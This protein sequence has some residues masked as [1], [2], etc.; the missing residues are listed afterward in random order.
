M[1]EEISK[2]DLIDALEDAIESH[3]FAVFL[4]AGMS[5]DAG[6]SNWKNLLEKPAKKIKLDIEKESYDLLNLAQ[7]YCNRFSRTKI[8]DLIKLEYDKLNKPTKN[9]DLLAQLPIYTYWTTNYDT[10]IED[11]LRNRNKKPNIKLKDV[12]LRGTNKTYD[13][14]VYKMHDDKQ[15]P[16]TAVITRSDYENFG[17]D[18]RKFFRGILEG[19]LL[20]KT[21]LFLG[22][23]FT[24]PN[25][26]HVI[27]RLRVLLNPHDTRKH[28]CIMKRNKENE[29]SKIKQELQIED[30]GRYNIS[31]YL[32]DDFAEI[33]E[34]LQILV[35]KYRR[36][37][38]FISGAAMNYSPLPE[39][40]GEM[41]IQKLGY[42]L[43]KNNY[44][45]VNGYGE[46]VGSYL[47][48]GVALYC[49]ENNKKTSEFLILMPFPRCISNKKIDE[50]YSKHR[51]QMIE[52]CGIS[53]FLFGNNNHQEISNGVMEE[54]E[55][56]EKLGLFP[57]P[58][59]CTGSAAEYIYSKVLKS[60]LSDSE[61]SVIKSCDFDYSDID[62]TISR[63]LN[64]INKLNRRE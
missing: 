38:I 52:T 59:R 40:D 63:I 4:G 64:I 46:G 55:I 17:F 21:F 22:V 48:N 54:Y 61:I 2:R 39:G 5:I 11:S 20:T 30:L 27:G 42:E 28:Y 1:K 23:S 13:A 57:V 43:A 31:T 10:L 12:D 45:I 44:K 36:K 56:S 37:T 50:I 49:Y 41:L 53:I 60:N 8:D 26:N 3:E 29:Y 58:I 24:D 9:H 19:D 32:V 15:S 34:I 18:E 51:M 47:L 14:I 25:F 35:D 62:D 6:F 33:T 16:N 7:Y